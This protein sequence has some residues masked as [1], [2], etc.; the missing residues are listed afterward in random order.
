MQIQIKWTRKALANLEKAIEL[1]AMDKPIAAQNVAKKIWNTVQILS[2][3]PGIG[4]PGRISGTRELI[5]SGLPFILPYVEKDGA[6]YILRV[7]HTSLK[8][9][10]KL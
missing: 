4:R 9:P 2:K 8:W 6:I 10:K 1:I 3:Q 7:M 5:I